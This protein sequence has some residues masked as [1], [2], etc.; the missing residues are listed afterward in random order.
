MPA[1]ADCEKLRTREK[2]VV[3]GMGCADVIQ[4][5]PSSKR[6]YCVFFWRPNTG[7]Y[8]VHVTLTFLTLI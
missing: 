3:S 7:V 8:F 2:T 6:H 5:K 4:E 1:L